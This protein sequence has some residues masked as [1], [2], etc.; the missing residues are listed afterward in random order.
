MKK[1]NLLWILFKE[2]FLLSMFTFGGGYVIIALMKKKFVDELHLLKEDEIL[3]ITTIA[4][5]GPGAVA[6]NASLLVGYKIKG[7]KGALTCV[8]ATIL[9]PMLILTTISYFYDQFI[10]NILIRNILNCMTAVV[11]AVILDIVFGMLMGIVK[12]KKISQYIS[13]SLAIIFVFVIKIDIIYLIF[14]GIGL[15]II[16]TIIESKRGVDDDTIN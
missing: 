16:Y 11:A 5:S 8:I 4:Q 1:D 2:C 7:F 12:G 3:D 6:V 14:M 13:L 9:P 10:H 15:G